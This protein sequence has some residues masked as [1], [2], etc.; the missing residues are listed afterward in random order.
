V[1]VLEP[2]QEA[3][4]LDVIAR[5]RGQHGLHA[6]PDV[7]ADGR[8][9]DRA[10]GRDDGPNSCTHAEMRVR[11]ECNVRVDEGHG[12][13]VDGLVERVALQD[14][15]EVHQLAAE[16]PD[17]RHQLFPGVTVAEWSVKPGP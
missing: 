13:R 2:V 16:V 8:G 17:V 3:H 10:V 1:Q 5:E 9:D 12:A 11:H 4:P 15:G 14:G 6:A 7:H